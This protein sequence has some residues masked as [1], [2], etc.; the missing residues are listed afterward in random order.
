MEPFKLKVNDDFRISQYII[1]LQG[2]LYIKRRSYQGYF[3]KK[4]KS[5]IIKKRERERESAMFNQQSILIHT[6][7]LF[8]YF[9][10][11]GESTKTWNLISLCY[12]S[13]LKAE[14]NSQYQACSKWS[15]F[16]T[17]RL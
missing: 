8:L 15:F 5:T 7:E 2:F 3:M 16:L 1:D 9:F 12:I 6:L 11:E 14:N 4:I 17:S 13:N 10:V